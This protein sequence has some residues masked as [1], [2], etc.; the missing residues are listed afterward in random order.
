MAFGVSA[1][2]LIETQQVHNAE[3]VLNQSRVA[4]LEGFDCA[5]GITANVSSVYMSKNLV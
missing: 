2:Y 5:I 3:T 1:E 4:P